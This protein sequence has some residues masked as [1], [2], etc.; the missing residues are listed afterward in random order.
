MED[1]R[2]L[3]S[4]EAKLA[5]LAPQLQ[6]LQ[7][8]AQ[9]YSALHRDL[10]LLREDFGTLNSGIEYRR[11]TVDEKLVSIAGRV[12]SI[13]DQLKGSGRSWSDWRQLAIAIAGTVI[14][15]LVL[16]YMLGHKP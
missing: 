6:S 9:D 15:T 10:E 16:V 4:L 1:E 8:L 14:S 7:E 5:V 13:E 3:A 12:A 2:L 11:T